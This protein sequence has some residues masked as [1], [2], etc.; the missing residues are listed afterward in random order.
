MTQAADIVAKAVDEEGTRRKVEIQKVLESCEDPAD[1]ARHFGMPNPAGSKIEEELFPIRLAM[2]QMEDGLL[3]SVFRMEDARIMNESGASAPMAT[4]VSS[5]T[6]ERVIEELFEYCPGGAGRYFAKP[7][8]VEAVEPSVVEYRLYACEDGSLLG[9]VETRN[10]VNRGL[11]TE[12]LAQAKGFGDFSD[13]VKS[14]LESGTKGLVDLFSSKVDSATAQVRLPELAKEMMLRALVG[15]LAGKFSAT[16]P[17]DSIAEFSEKT[18]SKWADA[19]T[20][21]WKEGVE[22]VELGGKPM[23]DLSALRSELDVPEAI[24]FKEAL[25]RRKA[26][27]GERAPVS[28]GQKPSVP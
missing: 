10:G 26:A 25:A 4:I 27:Q 28:G 7:G 3:A 19:S 2:K 5:K 18:L 6:A 16:V 15:S 24:S 20:K 11:S 13:E 12:V 21:K 9:R 8:R 17:Y 22:S 14:G 1:L 23:A